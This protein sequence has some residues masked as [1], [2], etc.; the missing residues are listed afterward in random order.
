MQ[1]HGAPLQLAQLEAHLARLRRGYPRVE[2]AARDWEPLIR[3]S[4]QLGGHLREE[5]RRLVAAAV[6]GTR[7]D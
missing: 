1:T 6:A 7:G 3:A 2:D 5:I 4:G